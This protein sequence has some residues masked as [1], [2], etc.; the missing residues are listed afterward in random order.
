MKFRIGNLPPNDTFNKQEWLSLNEPNSLWVTQAIAMPIGILSVAMNIYLLHHFGNL[1][2]PKFG[3]LYFLAMLLIIPVHECLHGVFFPGGLKS[4]H[5]TLGFDPKTTCFYACTDQIL[6]RNQYLLSFLAPLILLSVL[7]TLLL[8]LLKINS[9]LLVSAVL[10]NTFGS[11]GDLFSSYLLVNQV[12]S[13]GETV[14]DGL[15]TYWRVM[16]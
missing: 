1:T 12:P 16:P 13:N 5:T 2:I 11:C 3:G 10:V 14:N 7:P 6:R 4:K 15:A 9:S 8:I